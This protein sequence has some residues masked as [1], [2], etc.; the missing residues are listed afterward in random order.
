MDRTND[1]ATFALS[2]SLALV[3]CA[4]L[5]VGCADGGSHRRG[6]SMGVA[7]ATPDAGAWATAD[8]GGGW[9]GAADGGGAAADVAVYPLGPV[10]GVDAGTTPP[11]EPV[12]PGVPALRCGRTYDHETSHLLR[13]G[14][15][16]FATIRHRDGTSLPADEGGASCGGSGGCSEN[17][18]LLCDGDSLTGVLENAA[19]F[20]V[21]GAQS[22]EPG[23]GSLVVTLCGEELPAM[24]YAVDSGTLPGFVNGPQ[25][26]APLPTR[27]RCEVSVRAVGGCVWVRAVTVTCPT[28]PPNG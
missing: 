2:T 16:D 14:A 21:Q 24:S 25:P 12:L 27:E 13:G 18:T 6:G 20:S 17:V 26:A 4:V 1:R 22:G 11:I 5:A 15:P 23:T 28:A 9:G 7:P 19:T 3:A 10:P 8:G